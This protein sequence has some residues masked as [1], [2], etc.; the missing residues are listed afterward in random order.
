MSGPENRPVVIVGA[1]GHAKVLLDTLRSGDHSI[2]G[3]CDAAPE[4]A[5]TRLPGETILGDDNSALPLP[6]NTVTI[7]IGVGATRAGDARRTLFAQYRDAGFEMISVIHPSAVIAADVKIGA[8]AQIMAG[9]VIQ[10]GTSIG[11]NV[12]IN[13]GA[14]IDHDCRIGDHA[15]IAPGVT[16][17][18]GVTISAG[19]HIG[20]GATVLENRSVGVGAMIGGG[21]LVNRDIE[22]GMTAFGVPALIIR[23]KGN[24]A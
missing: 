3:L 18:G 1:G 7:V 4:K 6:T 24:N 23:D 20:A 17:C 2:Y 13:T 15:F 21:A 22:D 9:A 10:P 8:A 14:T 16:L 12:V 5:R 11:A 19:A